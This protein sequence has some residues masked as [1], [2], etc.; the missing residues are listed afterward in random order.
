MRWQS[1]ID[2]QN[3]R[4]QG[5]EICV[6]GCPLLILYGTSRRFENLMYV[7]VREWLNVHFIVG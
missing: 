2:L 3:K 6:E 5:L 7:Y 4:H 1:L